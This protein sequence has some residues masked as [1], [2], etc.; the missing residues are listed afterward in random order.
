MITVG[1]MLFFV[2]V[3]LFF[4]GGQIFQEAQSLYLSMYGS[5]AHYLRVIQ[6]AIEN[7]IQHILPGFVFNINAYVG[8]ILAVISNNLGTLV[9]QTLFVAF[10]TFLMLLAFFFFLRDGR[11]LLTAF[12]QLSPL[13]EEV[14]KEILNKMSRT[15]E[16]VMRG[17]LV[18]ALIRF[19]LIWIAFYLFGIPSA[20][21][22]SSIGAVVGAIPGLGT[23]FAFIPAIV[24]A[25]LQGNVLAVLG[26]AA[27]G[28]ATVIVVDNILTA[29]FFGKGFTV[30]PV[31]VLFSILGGIFF[32]GP[33]G[34][35]LGPLV[36]SVFLSVAHVYALEEVST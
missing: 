25:Y 15:I 27:F 24:Y 3:P 33:F 6:Y 13:G 5:G 8:N 22:W 35:I 16:A 36:L 17:T 28:I 9:Y 18:N 14:T 4:L 29:Y 7:P 11:N 19:A 26:L 21:L 20:I 32:F 12:V 31:F 30:S 1:L 10:E 34:F 23:P 2:I